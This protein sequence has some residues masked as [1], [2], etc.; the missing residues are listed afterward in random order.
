MIREHPLS[1]RPLNTANRFDNLSPVSGSHVIRVIKIYSALISR[2]R[3]RN[4]SKKHKLASSFFTANLTRSF[5]LQQRYLLL[6]LLLVNRSPID[7]VRRVPAIQTQKGGGD[8]IS[9]VGQHYWNTWSDCDAS[10]AFLKKR[11]SER[12]TLSD[13]LS[14][15]L[16]SFSSASSSLHC[17]P[18]KT[19][20]GGVATVTVTQDVGKQ[21]LRSRWLTAV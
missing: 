17:A 5:P 19:A 16:F 8:S 1:L 10:D 6:Y 2:M 4:Y 3:D 14:R 13:W 11:C 20:T 15:S 21:F 7:A 18:K 9:S 12:G